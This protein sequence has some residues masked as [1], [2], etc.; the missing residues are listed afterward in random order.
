MSGKVYIFDTTLR[1]GE[2]APGFSMNVDEKLKVALYLQNLR[3]D[4]I[5]A[6][7]PIASEGDFEAVRGIA[8]TIEGTEIA[9]LARANERDIDRAW[10]ALKHSKK[11]RIHVFI[12]T[13]DVH[14][15]YKLKMEPEEVLDR[16][17]KSVGFARKYTDNIEFSAEDAT[18]SNPDFLVKIFNAVIKAG[19]RVINVP[20]TVGYTTPDEFTELIGYIKDNVKKNPIISVHCHNDLGLA[21]ANTLAAVKAGARQ[22]ECTVNGIGE[23]A[24]NASLEEVVMSLKT[25]SDIFDF[26]TDIVTKNIYPTS[27]A[28]SYITGV[29]VQPNKAIVGRNAFA[30]EAG[31]HQDGVLKEKTTY[32]IMKPEDIGLISNLMILGKHSG[33]HAFRMRLKSLGY[34][35]SDDKL[36]KIFKK[37]KLLADKKKEIY[38]EDLE[39]LVDEGNF[40]KEI[41]KYELESVNCASG[42]NMTPVATVQIKVDGKSVKEMGWGDGPVDAVF[43]AIKKALNVECQLMQ[44]ITN[45]KSRSSDAQE[46]V[47]VHIEEKEK[48]SV[49]K[50]THTDIIIASAEAVINSLNRMNMKKMQKSQKGVD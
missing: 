29:S 45:N 35:F 32:E 50:G 30:H 43:N 23:R 1:D 12:A 15:K 40:S 27:S 31:I 22:A 37:F 49:G 39:I 10:E 16:A 46:E 44:F 26:H 18:R 41:K 19:A 17:V 36:N 7:F 48:Y 38:D 24:G 34:E 5:E 6:G 47:T 11:G 42:S 13:S 28:L 9:G 2:Q 14:M 8:K 25:R 33:R 20:D 3:V 21:V 4:I